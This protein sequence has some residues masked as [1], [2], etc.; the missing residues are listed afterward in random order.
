MFLRKWTLLHNERAMYVERA[1]LDK[2]KHVFSERNRGEII[3]HSSCSDYKFLTI[4]I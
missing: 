4:W 2:I 3:F 1:V